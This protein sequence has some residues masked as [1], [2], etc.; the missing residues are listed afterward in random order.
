MRYGNSLLVDLVLEEVSNDQNN[1][2]YY[3]TNIVEEICRISVNYFHNFIRCIGKT[4]SSLCPT[5]LSSTRLMNIKISLYCHVADFYE[6]TTLVIFCT[7]YE[8]SLELAGLGSIRRYSY[9][10]THILSKKDSH[11]S[12]RYLLF[13]AFITHPQSS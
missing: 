13:C 3:I 11:S 8:S 12:K 7:M 6:M 2:L 10:K 1:S 4:N 9:L 5:R